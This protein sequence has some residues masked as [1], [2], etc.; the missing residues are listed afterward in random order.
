M[1]GLEATCLLERLVLD[2][3]WHH[4]NKTRS[5]RLNTYGQPMAYLDSQASVGQ[6]VFSRASDF[7]ECIILSI[8]CGHPL[9]LAS[10]LITGSGR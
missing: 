2:R 10:H 1:R 8:S 3:N 4:V 5:F 7:I 9:T 6:L